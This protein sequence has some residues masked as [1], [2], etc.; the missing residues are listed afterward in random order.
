MAQTVVGNMTLST[1]QMPSHAHTSNYDGQI[2]YRV[3]ATNQFAGATFGINF[4]GPAFAI[5]ANGGGG[6]HNHGITMDIQYL[7]LILASKN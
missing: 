4:A 2:L 7:D 3:I 5:N 6:A 1:T